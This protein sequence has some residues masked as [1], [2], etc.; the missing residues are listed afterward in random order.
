MNWLDQYNPEV[1]LVILPDVSINGR[2][3]QFYENVI[4]QVEVVDLQRQYVDDVDSLIT[5]YTRK[6]VGHI[7]NDSQLLNP[8]DYYITKS[9]WS[10]T[11]GGQTERF[12]NYHIFHKPQHLNQVSHPS[13]FLPDSFYYS[14]ND[15]QNGFWSKNILESEV[16]YT[17]NGLL[18]AGE[19]V[20]TSYYDTTE[21]A[22]YFIEKSYR[23]QED[24]V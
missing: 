8:K 4:E 24:Q 18:R 16:L 19:S 2:W 12:Y 21:I 9:D 1:M 11:S 23:V 10:K 14:S 5:L 13:Y 17:Y 20:D 15:I 7:V 3:G 22:I 6:E